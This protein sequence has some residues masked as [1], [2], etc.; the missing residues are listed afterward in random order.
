MTVGRLGIAEELNVLLL[1]D[2]SVKLQSRSP[3]PSVRLFPPENVPTGV[4]EDAL[5]EVKLDV[6]RLIKFFHTGQPIP[7][8]G[9]EFRG[10]GLFLC[11]PGAVMMSD[12]G[13]RFFAMERATAE[14][15][16]EDLH[17]L[18]GSRTDID[19]RINLSP[20]VSTSARI[21]GAPIYEENSFKY[22]DLSQA[23][24]DSVWI[25]GQHQAIQYN[26]DHPAVDLS[27]L[28]KN[29]DIGRSGGKV[30]PP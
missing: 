10:L 15:Q 21:R 16:I 26:I 7:E 22:S 17:F 13:S 14:R 30:P 3:L 29:L 6:K 18:M 19:I 4:A 20:S 9:D 1:S 23:E 2:P 25:E 28:K 24:K 8:G 11:Q 5:V 27:A 12:D